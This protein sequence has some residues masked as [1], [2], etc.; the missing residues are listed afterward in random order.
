MRAH[1]EL[2]MNFRICSLPVFVS[3]TV[4]ALGQAAPDATTLEPVIVYGRSLDLVG[5]SASAAEGQ[6]GSAELAV[7]PF[8]RRGELLEVV[9]GVVVTQHSG[10]GK[11]NQC[12]LRGFNS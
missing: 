9:P 11:A 1:T 3:F 4:L 10:S 12:F 6:V 7:R 5:D 2:F 8:L